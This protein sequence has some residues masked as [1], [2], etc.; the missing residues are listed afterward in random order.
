MQKIIL[1]GVDGAGKTALYQRYFGKK[2]SEALKNLPP[3]RGIA[4]YEHDFLRSDVQI[5]DLGGSKEYR[6][7]Y[8]GNKE[9]VKGLSAIVYIIDVQDASKFQETADFL[10]K[11]TRSVVDA[12]EGV[13][14]YVLFHKIDPGM[15]GQLKDNLQKIAKIISPIG[16]IYPGQLIKSI[17]TIYSDSSNKVFQR[18]LLDTL[19]RRKEP[20]TKAPERVPTKSSE[21]VAEKSF[22]TTPVS[23]EK[24]PRESPTIPSE[25]QKVETP[26]T[27]APPAVEAAPPQAE[28]EPAT[29]KDKPPVS[30]PALGSDVPSS[31]EPPAISPPSK[32]PTSQAEKPQKIKEKTAERLTDIIEASLN[33]NP[34][35]V[36]IAVFSDTAECVVGTISQGVNAEIL[37]MLANTLKKINLEEYMDR[38]GRVSIGGEGHLQIGD[39]DIFFEKVSPDHLSS[40]ICSSIQEETIKNILQ[41]NRYL[42]QALSVTPDGVDEETF[43]R[44]DLM[45]ELK[46]KLKNRGRSV[47]HVG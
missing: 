1:L 36:A 27:R 16:G 3:T 34:E 29:L 9:L 13:A 20:I 31:T 24:S 26:S 37:D 41:I 4:K 46:M 32:T 19:P 40:V 44:A 14:G 5:L 33:N 12:L 6:E 17:T 30:P 42:N 22:I 2:T 39:Y 7:N 11:W 8:I 38:L 15:E 23:A 18:I 47:D 35:F 28:K 21:P 43:L 10:I 45:S 25:P